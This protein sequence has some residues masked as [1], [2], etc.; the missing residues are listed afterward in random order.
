MKTSDRIRVRLGR[1][2]DVS[3]EGPGGVRWAVVV[4]VAV[5]LL[6]GCLGLFGVLLR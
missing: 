6:A 1:F 2:V 3:G 5:G 4:V